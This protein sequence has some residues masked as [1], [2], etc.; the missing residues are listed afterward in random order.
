M[1]MGRVDIE[2]EL[3]DTRRDVLEKLKR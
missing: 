1:G 3:S 2:L